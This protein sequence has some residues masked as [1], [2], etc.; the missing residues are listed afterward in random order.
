M[1]GFVSLERTRSRPA[2]VFLGKDVLFAVLFAV[3]L[4]VRLFLLLLFGGAG[5]IRVGLRVVAVVGVGVTGGDVSAAG[6]GVRSTG[7][8]VGFTTGASVNN[9]GPDVG[10]KR[11]ACVNATGLAVGTMTGASVSIAVGIFVGRSVG[12]P[13][14]MLNISVGEE[15]GIGLRLGASFGEVVGI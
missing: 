11:G 1:D 10:S 8:T 2:I 9:T 14:T 4:L 15:L 3:L 7:L 6:F 13:V 12:S 5:L